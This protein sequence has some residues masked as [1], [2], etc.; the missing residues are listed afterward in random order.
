MIRTIYWRRRY[1]KH[2]EDVAAAG[3]DVPV[4]RVGDADS[5]RPD[6]PTLDTSMATPSPPHS[7]RSPGGGRLS[8]L[9]SPGDTSSVLWPASPRSPTEADAVADGGGEAAQWTAM[10]DDAINERDRAL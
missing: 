9:G 2:R 10:M 7:P 6:R 8:P 5:P 4:I 3:A 1:L